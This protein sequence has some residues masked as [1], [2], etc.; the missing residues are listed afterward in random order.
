MTSEEDIL[1]TVRSVLAERCGVR[2]DVMLST[3]LSEDLGL[4]STG[5]LT[6]ALELENHYRLQ[7]GEDPE[8]PPLSVGDVVALISKGLQESE[9]GSVDS[10]S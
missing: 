3:K 5:L 10:D 8:S 4:D 2:D 9:R 7:L 6:L 1:K